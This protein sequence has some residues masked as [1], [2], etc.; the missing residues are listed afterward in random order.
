[1]RLL[2]L[3]HDVVA[4]IIL[5]AIAALFWLLFFTPEADAQE[6]MSHP[7]TGEV[8]V[9]V[10]TEVQRGHLLTDAELKTCTASQAKTQAALE[11]KKQEAVDLR[12]ALKA[13]D[14]AQE[15]I[16]TT[17]A[18]TSIALEEEEEHNQALIHWLYGTSGVAVV[19]VAL[20]VVLA[21]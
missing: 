2:Q 3:F 20:V 17:L 15:A 21:L 4:V 13:A 12:V 14:E 18:A 11:E 8:G 9:W 19:A 7:K 1:M 6:K 16:T 10:P 5:L